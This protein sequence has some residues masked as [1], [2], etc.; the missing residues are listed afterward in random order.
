MSIEYSTKNKDKYF[1]VNCSGESSE[2]EVVSNYAREVSGLCKKQGYKRMLV[3]ER[4]REYKLSEVLDLYKLANFFV[5]LDISSIRIAIVCQPRYIDHVRF[6]ETTVNNRGMQIKYFV[7]PDG[8]KR[9][10]L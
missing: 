10:L 4:K 1:L 5:T 2:L 6:F 8:A 9:W 3:D 7:D